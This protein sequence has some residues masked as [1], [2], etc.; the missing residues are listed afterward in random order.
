MRDPLSELLMLM[1]GLSLVNC[2]ASVS[3]AV[4]FGICVV[5][6]CPKHNKLIERDRR[7]STN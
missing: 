7:V 3:N 5:P 1:D 6:V 2:T 4:P